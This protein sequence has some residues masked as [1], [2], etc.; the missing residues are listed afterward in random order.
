MFVILALLLGWAAEAMAQTAPSAPGTSPAATP[1]AEFA[2]GGAAGLIAFISVIALLVILG[3]V[4]KLVDDLKSTCETEVAR[5][6]AQ[7]SDALLRDQTLGRFPVTP[8]AH[9]PIW[10]GAPVT[11]QVSGRVPTPEIRQAAL[12]VVEREASRIRSDF[13]IDDRIE[14]VPAMVSRVA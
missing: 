13:S 12:R 6:Q 9:V 4:G 7:I 14:V 5:L 11:I 10:R 8:T 2:E 1:P 3:I